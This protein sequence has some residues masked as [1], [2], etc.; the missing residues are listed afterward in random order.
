MVRKA[1]VAACAALFMTVTGATGAALATPQVSPRAE[2]G[3]GAAAADSSQHVSFHKWS[4]TAAFARGTKDGV[5]VDHDSLSIARTVGTREYTDPFGDSGA[6]RYDYATWTSPMV[7]PGF[8]LSEL[9]ASWNAQTPGHTWV[10]VEMRG[11]ADTGAMSKWYVMGRWA[12]N[13][14]AAGG[15]IHRTSVPRQGDDLGYVA[16]DTFVASGG[17]SLSRYQLRVTLYRPH[18]TRLSPTVSLVGAMASRIDVPGHVPASPLGGAEGITLDVPAYSQEVHNGQYPQWD[19]GGEAWCSPT[20]TSMVLAYWRSGPKPEDYAW[21]D[22]AYQDPWV[23]HAARNTYDYNYDGAGNWPFNAAY[24]GRFGVEGF[25][26]RLRSLTEAEQFIKHGIPLVV[27]VS[28]KKGELDGAG[29]STGG[30][31]M[32]IVGFT[33]DGDVV[34]N[35]PASHLIPSNDQVRT[36]YDREQ[37]ENTWIPHSGGVAYV[38]HPSDVALPPAPAEANW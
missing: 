19:G 21:V 14:P 4:R 32:V 36:V 25:V 37:F 29:Y 9:I 20:S 2:A 13:D 26:T 35:D 34:V 16:I 31:L 24:A 18:G 6:R 15:A 27:S 11:L 10:Q 1:L 8:D 3:I 17:H 38:I 28:W 33:K 30:H 23:D 7:T 12:E 22:P 5:R